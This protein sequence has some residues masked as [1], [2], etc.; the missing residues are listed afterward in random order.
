MRR[1]PPQAGVLQH[2]VVPWLIPTPPWDWP[3]RWDPEWM[4]VVK[5]RPELAIPNFPYLCFV[6]RDPT[7]HAYMGVSNLKLPSPSQYSAAMSFLRL[8]GLH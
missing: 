2:K 8:L 5:E 6:A 3:R 4:S 1:R 7:E